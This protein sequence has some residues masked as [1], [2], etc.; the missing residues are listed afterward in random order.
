[1]STW[2]SSRWRW[3]Q[4]WA[5]CCHL[6]AA[7]SP[8]PIKCD[9][10]DAKDA[11]DIMVTE[12]LPK[13]RQQRRDLAEQEARELRRQEREVAAALEAENMLR[14]AA[15]TARRPTVG[16]ATPVP[17]QYRTNLGYMRDCK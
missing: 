2:T 6:S 12:M 5:A 7:L 15:I 1:M 13:R 10:K 17:R 14:G 16:P 9:V 11:L 8:L 4:A 3:R